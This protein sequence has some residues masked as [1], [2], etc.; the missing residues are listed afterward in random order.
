MTED[1][2]YLK[3]RLSQLE[4]EHNALRALYR[5]PG[6]VP[7]IHGLH[8]V[9]TKYQSEYKPDMLEAKRV[10]ADCLKSPD[11]LLSFAAWYQT[12]IYGN[13]SFAQHYGTY[14]TK[15]GQSLTIF[16]VPPFQVQLFLFS[17]GSVITPHCHPNVESYEC[18]VA[19]DMELTIDYQDGKGLVPTTIKEF[20][21]PDEDG[22][23]RCN[24]AMLRVPAGVD[25]GG[26]VDCV[27]AGARPVGGAFISI[28]YWRNGVDPSGVQFDWQG[29]DGSS[30]G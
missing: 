10:C 26:H 16:R 1:I 24:G 29:M 5:V 13:L 4:E 9:M 19:G 14:P 8:A 2:T 28:Q 3:E 6:H 27:T 7:L 12:H 15:L 17:E 21:A 23:T 11:P 22:R 20:I 25:H 30:V 18:Y